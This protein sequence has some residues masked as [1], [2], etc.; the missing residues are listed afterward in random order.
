METQI[1]FKRFLGIIIFIFCSFATLSIKA[2]VLKIHYLGHSAFVL[3]FDN[4]ITVVTD[5]GEP[6]AWLQWGW[7]SPIND[8]GDLVPNVMTYS[9]TNH[10]DHYDP[11]RIPEGVEHILMNTDSLT[12]SGLTITPIRV[13]ESNINVEDN[14]AFLFSYKGF[15]FLHLGDAQAQIKNIRNP[16]VKNHIA[17]IIPDSL[18][19]LF[20]TIEGPTQFIEEAEEFV[21]LVKLKRI[22]PM[23]YWSEEYLQEFC[24]YLRLQNDSGKT[25]QINEVG[26][27]KYDINETDQ[28]QPIEVVCLTRSSFYSTTGLGYEEKVKLGFELKQNYPNPFNPA[29]NI[30]FT[31]PFQ[32]DE[33]NS[34]LNTKL[35]VYDTLGNEIVELV[36]RN[37]KPGN[38]EVTF[39]AGSLSSGVY[40][41]SL[42]YGSF[43][44]TKKMLLLK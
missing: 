40:Y 2:E 14:T 41:Y 7:D 34:D 4:G 26:N 43:C 8:I 35:I 10:E 39:D 33:Y 16:D 44:S 1:L 19:L 24:N 9:H 22:I 3:E 27:A 13:C 37:L 21:D 23:H 11:T 42:M 30:K 38:Y 28:P 18:D 5:Y 17:E 20:M 31:I 15:K 36:N 25:Y 6:N 12:V 32:N 29:T